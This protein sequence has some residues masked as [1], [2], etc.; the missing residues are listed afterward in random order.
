[1]PRAPAALKAVLEVHQGV[2]DGDYPEHLAICD[3][4]GE[5]DPCPTILA[6]TRALTGPE[7]TIDYRTEAERRAADE[8]IEALRVKL[9][10]ERR[11]R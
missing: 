10:G 8:A 5:F 3:E 1:M 11:Q 6:I 9:A 7:E 4:D 2:T